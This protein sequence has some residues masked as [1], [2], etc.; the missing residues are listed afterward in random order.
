MIHC[1][2]LFQILSTDIVLQDVNG[3]EQPAVDV[4]SQSLHFMKEHL[5]R[6]LAGA[7]GY[8]PDVQTI[9]W[10]ITVPA[11][12]DENAKQFMREAAYKVSLCSKVKH[13]ELST[14]LH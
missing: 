4:F 3:K 1:I 9:R 12:W 7:M 11:I 14:L 8:T 6:H 13:S 10:V 2:Q 5:L